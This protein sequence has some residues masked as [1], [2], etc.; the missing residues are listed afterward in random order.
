MSVAF[1]TKCW[2][3]DYQK[4]LAGAFERK[5]Q[6]CKHDF[7]TV[8]LVVNNGSSVQDLMIEWALRGNADVALMAEELADDTMAY[9]GLE[10]D[11]FGR[12][13]VYSIAELTA[14]RHCQEDYLCYVQGDCLVTTGD[15]V[16]DAIAV[17]EDNPD[18]WAVSP[19]SDVNTWHGQD[20]LDQYFS[21]QAWL[22]RTKDWQGLEFPKDSS[23]V[24]GYPE[25]GGDLFERKAA[26]VLRQQGKFRKIL[27]DHWYQHPTY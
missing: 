16:S 17:L 1:Y 21:D 4:M 26:K 3:G 9:F 13:Y 23:D 14:I 20:G 15:W 6:A 24:T 18:V 27:T 12:G 25:Y 5:W 8:G 7:D 10:R 11:D 2:E 19:A 22:V